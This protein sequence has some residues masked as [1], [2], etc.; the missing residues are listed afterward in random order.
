M[1]R[2]VL[3]LGL[4]CLLGVSF[5]MAA[6]LADPGVSHSASTV[7]TLKSAQP[8]ATPQADTKGRGFVAVSPQPACTAGAAFDYTDSNG[9][10]YVC[11]GGKVSILA[12]SLSNTCAYPT[13]GA[14]ATPTPTV[15][16]TP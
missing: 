3:G 5:F 15:T 11:S 8:T 16:A 13:T 1:K 12:R 10:I 6:L 2:Q 4:S 9:C 14:T 7:R